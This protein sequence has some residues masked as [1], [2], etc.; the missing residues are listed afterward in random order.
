MNSKHENID[1]DI[2]V[3]GGG[4]A[5]IL[6]AIR[7]SELVERVLLVSKATTG[8]SGCS[9]WAAGTMMCYLP[10]VDDEDL[11]VEDILETSELLDEPEMARTVVRE[12]YH[13][14]MEM[15]KFGVPWVRNED[16]EILRKHGIG[17][18]YSQ[19]AMFRGGAMTMWVLRGEAARRGVKI[20]DR[21]TFTHLLTSD[22]HLPTSGRVVGCIAF[23]NRTGTVYT[24]Q[25][26][27]TVLATGDWNLKRVHAPDDNTGDG[28]AA[29]FQAGGLL[30]CM[31]QFCYTL[32]TAFEGHVSA[33][34]SLLGH[35]TKLMNAKG[36][37]F[38]ER[39]DPILKDRA[40][41]P[42]L[43]RSVAREILA[44][45][46]PVFFDC[47]HLPEEVLNLMKGVVPRFYQ[48]CQAA[49]YDI[50]KDPIPF[51]HVPF[52]NGSAGGLKINVWGETNIPGLFAGGGVTD[53]VGGIG[54]NGLNGAAV[55]GHLAGE[56]AG[57]YARGKAGENPVPSQVREFQ[58]EIAG[59]SGTGRDQEINHLTKEL[60]RICHEEI[61]IIKHPLRLKRAA[62]QIGTILREEIPKLRASDPHHLSKLYD[63]RNIATLGEITAR[64]SLIREESRYFHFREDFPK[65]DDD[66]W[67]KYVMTRL[68]P[69]GSP[70][71]YLDEIP[72]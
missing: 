43:T 22:G 52:G 8:R 41:R 38:M 62:S 5:G 18:R 23:N 70:E 6:S 67:R 21:V 32:A 29:A 44:G 57:Q 13:R 56:S 36:E 11:W 12:T 72:R 17:M 25:A 61:G 58:M 3:C 19:N 2:L 68:G 4:I 63:V 15:D 7:A 16:G 46:G 26:K 27:A 51:V 55:F 59:L 64:A 53:R 42:T 50:K 40:N 54:T 33:L 71:F 10:S 47:R 65:R 60:H 14:V 39:Y 28:Q 1:C 69:F 66:N 49:G 24:I 9:Y 35:G 37:Y 34:H 48:M 31:D 30:R 45:R 20:M